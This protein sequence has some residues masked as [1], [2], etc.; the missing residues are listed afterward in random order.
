M[1]TAL[2]PIT[3]RLKVSVFLDL[4]LQPYNFL[5]YGGNPPFYEAKRYDKDLTTGLTVSYQIWKGLE[6]NVHYYFIRDD[7]N[8]SLYNYNRHLA[9]VQ[10]SYRY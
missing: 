6:G 10:L 9:G 8:I 5:F 2:Y 4:M 3:P 7:S 1:T